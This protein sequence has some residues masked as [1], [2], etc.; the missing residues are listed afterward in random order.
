MGKDES[1]GPVVIGSGIRI[2]GTVKGSEPVVLRGQIDGDVTLPEHQLTVE[3]PARLVGDVKAKQVTVRGE[4]AGSAEA[5][6]RIHVDA[7]A[8]VVGDVR[9]SRLVVVDGARL[10]GRVQMTV[11]LPADLAAKVTR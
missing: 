10:S 3:S 6:E 5:S 7:G 4:L 2:T 8:R 9:T 11:D 1:N